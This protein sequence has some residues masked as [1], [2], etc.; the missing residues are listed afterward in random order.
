MA[1]KLYLDVDNQ[2]LVS[3]IDSAIAAS[4][5][6]MFF[7]D[8]GDYE[9]YFLATGTGSTAFDTL[10][11]SAKTVKLAIGAA[12]PST[13][14][15]YVAQNTWSDTSATVSATI[16]RTITGGT[17]IN[18]Q[19]TVTFTPDAF[20][21]TFAISIPSRTLTFSTVTAGIWTT[22][23]S[24]GLIA[25]EPFA[26]TGFGTPTG[27]SN[28]GTLYCA[29]V[30]DSTR[31]Y[32]AS[33]A[34]TTAIT[35]ATCTT[36]G[37]G[38]T[39]TATTSALD[40]RTTPADV[41]T[42]IESLASVGAGNIA[43]TGIAGRLYRLSYEA[44]KGQ[45]SYPLPTVTHALTPVYGKTAALDFNTTELYNAISASASIAA[46]LE[47]EV[48]EGGKVQTVLQTGVTI[49]NNIIGDSS[50][51]PVNPN[52]ATSFRAT[53]DSK[54]TQSF[55]AGVSDVLSWNPVVEDEWLGFDA[56]KTTYTIPAGA[57]G[58]WQFNVM[59]FMWCNPPGVLM[60][61][62]CKNSTEIGRMHA[63]SIND[64]AQATF[65]STARCEAGDAIQVKCT[66]WG[67]SGEVR[68]DDG[69]CFFDGRLV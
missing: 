25:L 49:S 66:V 36:A 21:G 29:Q 56:G 22:S 6:S 69:V 41:Q 17:A 43:V 59:V 40:A 15:A 24:H 50:P 8:S 31:F 67:A 48:S 39:I 13:A 18:E 23:G 62:L 58:L 63:A 68:N 33:A 54:T 37:T 9:L 30:I 44:N 27:F 35:S 38:Y 16:A 14:T 52:V 1:R 47:I 20:D 55:S 53:C 45:F 5:P 61:T 12:P 3:G 65:A 46:T 11:Y 4:V 60:V 51:T 32:A 2:R 57:G 34:T 10:D 19:Q 26:V 28:G 7:A 42:A 64:A